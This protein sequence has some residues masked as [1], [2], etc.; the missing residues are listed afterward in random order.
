MIPVTPFDPPTV[1][2]VNN[3][4][5]D[6]ALQPRGDEPRPEELDEAVEEEDADLPTLGRPSSLFP[7]SD[8]GLP[9]PIIVE[10]PMEPR[11]DDSLR[12]PFDTLSLFVSQEIFPLPPPFK[13][14]ERTAPEPVPATVIPPLRL[15]LSMEGVGE[16]GPPIWDDSAS[17]M[18]GLVPNDCCITDCNILD[19]YRTMR[20][21]HH[22]LAFSPRFSGIIPHIMV[23]SIF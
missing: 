8:N 19:F 18:T 2:D 10:V 16:V 20:L 13:T 14:D 15:S 9:D 4:E 3:E 5:A 11:P 7:P 22:K 6:D 12:L 1:V 17:P 23:I 21:C